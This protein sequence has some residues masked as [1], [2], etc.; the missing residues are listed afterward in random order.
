VGRAGDKPP[1]RA[2]ALRAGLGLAL[3]C[4]GAP[5]PFLLSTN[6]APMPNF[7]PALAR[8][9]AIPSSFWST[10]EALPALPAF[11][12][13]PRNVRTLALSPSSLSVAAS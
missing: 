6:S 9:G 2:G 7:V 11:V 4:P 12:G 8:E 3:S 10:G 13:V 1:G 5:L